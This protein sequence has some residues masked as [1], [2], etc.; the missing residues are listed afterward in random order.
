MFVPNFLF[1]ANFL[2]YVVVYSEITS[3]M[4]LALT[5][6]HSRTANI[7]HNSSQRVG[8]VHGRQGSQHI[9]HTQ[10]TKRY[11][12][13]EDD[14]EYG[15]EERDTF[16]ENQFGDSSVLFQSPS[17]F[18]GGVAEHQQFTLNPDPLENSSRGNPR[19]MASKH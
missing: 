16:D 14:D 18:H 12:S 4:M 3:V 1:Y 10:E 19:Y 6:V 11:E 7:Q 17:H 5:Y 2:F 8:D 15:D 9:R 13:E